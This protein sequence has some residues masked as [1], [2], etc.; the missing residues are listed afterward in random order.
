VELAQKNGV[1]QADNI[2]L[3]FDK[4]ECPLVAKLPTKL[5]ADLL[6]SIRSA[7]LSGPKAISLQG[8]H[9]TIGVVVDDLDLKSRSPRKVTASAVVTQNSDLDRASVGTEFIVKNIHKQVRLLVRADENGDI[10]A[11]LPECLVTAASLKGSQS[12]KQ[13]GPIPLSV[14]LV[15]TALRLPAVKGAKPTLQ[16]A[17]VQILVGNFMHLSATAALSGGA[18]RQVVTS[19]TVRLDLQR[20]LLFAAPFVPSGMKGDGGVTA[21]WDLAAPLPE[22]AFL[23]DKNPLRSAKEGMA[24]LDKFDIGVKLDTVSATFPSAKGTIEISGLRTEPDLHFSSLKKGDSVLFGGGLLFSGVSGLSGAAGK[25]SSQHA[26]LQFNGKITDWSAMQLHEKLRVDPLELSQ[27][28]ELNVNRIDSLLDEKEPFSRATL[29]KRL[30]ATLFATADAALSREF[31][32]LLPGLNLAGNFSGSA[33]LDLTA[34][35]ELGLRSTI[36]TSDF[37][38]QLENGTKV[39]GMRS[40]IIFNRVYSLASESQSERWTPLSSALVRPAAAISSNQGSAEIVGRIHEDLRGDLNG[41]RSFSI[42]KV[43]TKASG[44]PLIL[45]ALEGDLLFTKEKMGLSFLQ[46]DLLGG[47]LLAHSVFDLKPEVPV[48]SAAGSFSNLDITQLLPKDVKKRRVN[49]NAEITGEM[50]LTAPLTAEQRELFEQLRL[51]MNIRKIGADTIEQALFS[52][53]PYERNEQVVAQRKTLRLGTLKGLRVTAVDGAL[54]MEGEAVVKGLAIDLPKVERL[55]ISELP[56]RQEL[57]K[58]RKSIEALRG[59]LGLMRSDTLVVGPKGELS[60]K[61]RGYEK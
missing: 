2:D 15:A 26:S 49:E 44:V 57:V 23:A 61:R 1:L 16:R 18:P 50:S 33:R 46:T 37:G 58:N 20:G 45:T 3:V 39:E 56:L 34:G 27:E 36:K 22:K 21:E 54:S 48:I 28:A 6:W 38:V 13:F 9:G 10:E 7:T 11:A 40:D 53:D 59:L 30:D 4:V 8:G 41:A 29:I 47:T 12:G 14:S 60:L 5:V 19:G 24:L 17:A 31:K 32:Q 55:R 52:L 42:K 35:R 25:L 51:T 43:T